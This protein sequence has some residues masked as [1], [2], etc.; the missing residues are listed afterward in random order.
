M[1]VLWPIK[2][3]PA[4][5]PRRVHFAFESGPYLVKLLEADEK[6]D[7]FRLRHDIFHHEHHNR[8]LP[9]LRDVDEIDEYSDHLGV[10]CAGRLVG[11]YRLNCTLYSSL[12]YASDRFDLAPLLSLPG[13]KVELGR[14]CVAGDSRKGIALHLLWRGIAE[15]MKRTDCRYL[16]GCSSIRST[17][18]QQVAGYFKFLQEHGHLSDS[19]WLDVLAHRRYPD[20]AKELNGAPAEKNVP[21]LMKAYFKAGAK[22][23]AEPAC[24]SFMYCAD[25]LTVLDAKLVTDRIGRRY[26]LATAD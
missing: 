10:Y 21:T 25:F 13:N 18:L 12:F 17:D 23:V 5:S 22:V 19:L 6:E 16:F 24:D 8:T 14:A 1:V 3:P 26:Q 20:F 7:A 15:Y 2:A 9:E 4:H 11:T